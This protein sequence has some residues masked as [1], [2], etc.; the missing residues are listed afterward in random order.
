MKE[1]LALMP[2]DYRAAYLRAKP[3]AG[4]CVTEY[5][6]RTKGVCAVTLANQTGQMYSRALPGVRLCE[7]DLRAVLARLCGGS[8]H[9][10]D[11]G[12]RRGYLTPGGYPGVR[13]GIAGR[14]LCE[15]GRVVRLQR[16][17]SLCIRLPHTWDIPA[18]EENRLRALVLSGDPDVGCGTSEKASSPV[19]RRAASRPVSILFYAPP[20]EGKTTL[21]RA[22]IC[23][24]SRWD[25]SLEEGGALRCAVIDSGEELYRENGVPC[26]TDWF[27]GYP[28]G[29][30]ISVA[31]R[32]FAPEVLVCDE[33]GDEEEA[34]QILRAQG[35]GVPLI[36]TAHADT[37]SELL[38]RPAFRR[39]YE[40]NVFSKYIRLERNA[41]GFSF[42]CEVGGAGDGGV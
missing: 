13:V 36:A 19:T 20:G 27:S 8:V 9:A 2:E 3:D 18:S 14:V 11:E 4:A 40:H 12:V 10:Y 22:V 38:R 26:M 17:E 31:V 41:A 39:L 1:L 6:L 5:R 16:P 7:D 34:E 33:I 28:R 30:G 29:V 21:L 35:M 42:H 32:A 25:V 37:L 24:L 15:G 23:A